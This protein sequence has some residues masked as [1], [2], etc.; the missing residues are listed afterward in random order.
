MTYLQDAAGLFGTGD[1]VVGFGQRGADGLFYQ[2]VDA[3]FEQGAGDGMVV[4]GGNGDGGGVE[5]QIGFQK[6]FDRRKD[7]DAVLGFGFGG[8]AGV[9]VDG[10]GKLDA[11]AGLF[12]F[13]IDTKVVAP[14]GSGAGNGDTQLG[15]ACY[16]SAPFP[17][18]ALRQRP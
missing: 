15:A 7:G 3:G 9:G 5:A 11:C 10:R 4:D 18:T 16:F 12:Q 1:Q 14:E 17:S 2:D 13:A 8:V 6:L